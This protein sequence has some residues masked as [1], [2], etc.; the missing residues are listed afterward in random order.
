MT[1]VVICP[2]PVLQFFNN[3][4]TPAAGGSVLTQ[5]S[6]VNAPTYSDSAGT[7]LLPNPIPLNSRGEVSTSAGASSQLFL[8]ANTV[9]TFTLFDA[10]GNQIW[11]A[12]YL[13]GIQI[14]IN[15]ALLGPLIYPQT[16]AELAANVTPSNFIYPPYDI[17]RY[18]ADPTGVV[19]SDAARAA[20][21]AVAGTTGATIRSP[22]G[23]YTFANPLDL[24]GKTYLIFQGD[25]GAA[26]GAPAATQWIYTGTQGPMI[27][28][29]AAAGVWFRDMQLTHN[30]A[31]F[32][33]TYIQGGN[34]GT[35]DCNMCGISNCV[36]GNVINGVGNI[37]LDLDR[38]ILFT[39]T[40]CN[41]LYGNP[42]VR[43]QKSDGTHYSNV[44]RFRDCQ[45]VTSYVPPVQQGGQAWLLSGCT[46]EGVLTATPNVMTAGGIASGAS[47]AHFDGLVVEGCWFGDATSATPGSWIN[48]F[49]GEAIISGNYISGINPGSSGILFQNF[50]GAMV[51]GN[52]FAG[53]QVGINFASATS[54][55]IICQGNTFTSVGSP[56]ATLTNITVGTFVWGPNFGV[57][58]PPAGHGSLSANGYEVNSETGVITQWGSVSVTSGTPVTVNF[59]ANG[60]NFPTAVD[61]VQLTV[62][63]PGTVG[64][65]PYLSGSITT[66]SFTANVSGTGSN[67]VYWEAKGN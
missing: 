29:T 43:G 11:V 27:T 16:A 51:T 38:T 46:F 63:T 5:V 61:G 49:G 52:L 33:G 2:T 36:L 41:F 42:S 40:G 66:S 15:Q 26:G 55:N 23:P 3:D 47:T 60:I 67:T 65:V 1:S 39:A 50:S 14:I 34:N 32:T 19:P 8:P 12:P 13:N 17:R 6:A 37:H 35:S 64:N 48:I 44:I 56:Y 20:A 58:G 57:S 28:I 54:K 4:G 21:I 18:G 45:W 7:I 24:T 53:L 9:Y 25:G 30:N 10:L 31:L 62:A 22:G 59:N